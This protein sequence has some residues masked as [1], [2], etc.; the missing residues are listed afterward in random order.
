MEADYKIIFQ[1]GKYFLA[2]RLNRRG[3]YEYIFVGKNLNHAYKELFRL[4]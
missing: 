1:I 3:L 2:F 4:L